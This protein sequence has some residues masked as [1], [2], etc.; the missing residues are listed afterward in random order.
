MLENMVVFRL[1]VVL[2]PLKLAPATGQ[3]HNFEKHRLEN[4]IGAP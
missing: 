4:T 1:N 2:F 3:G